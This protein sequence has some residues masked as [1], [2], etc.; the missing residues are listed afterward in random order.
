MHIHDALIGALLA[1]LG[2]A[3][4]WHVAGFPQVAG[5][6]YGPG[7]FPRLVGAGLVLFGGGL[8]LRGMRAGALSAL[9][10]LPEPALLRRAVLAGLYILAAVFSIVLLGEWVGVQILVFVTMAVGLFAGLRHPLGALL[11]A[12]GLT[13]AF[14]LIFRVLLKVPLPSGPLTGL[15]S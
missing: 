2:S 12:G 5:Q 9:V 6:I 11:L 15:I 4:I 13:I 14:D 3:V 10:S 8:I 7:L 1:M